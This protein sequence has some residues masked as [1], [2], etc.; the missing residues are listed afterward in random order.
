MARFENSVGPIWRRIKGRKKP[1]ISLS[2]ST[3]LTFLRLSPWFSLDVSLRSSLDASLL[4][5]VLFKRWR[6]ITLARTMFVYFQYQLIRPYTNLPHLLLAG[7]VRIR[8][9]FLS[10]SH[11]YIHQLLWSKLEVK[12]QCCTWQ[13]ESQLFLCLNQVQGENNIQNLFTCIN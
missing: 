1:L 4:H 13:D 12:G 8:V 10:T 3:R 7:N 11:N 5:P 6:L 9:R 2:T